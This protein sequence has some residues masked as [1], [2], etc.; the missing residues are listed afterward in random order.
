MTI[1]HSHSQPVCPGCETTVATPM[2]CF[3]CNSIQRLNSKPNYFEV[4]NL[5]YTYDLDLTALEESYQSLAAELHPDFY[6]NAPVSE[7]RQSQESSAL[8]NQAYDT[9]LSPILRA[10]YLLEL[11]AHGK[12]LDERKLPDGFLQEMFFLQETLEDTLD[13][14]NQ[15]KIEEIETSV[16][17][18]LDKSNHGISQSFASYT[19]SI[20]KKAVLENIQILLN[21]NTYL[22][23]LLDRI[24]R[25]KTL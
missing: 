19:G 3:S 9:L 8:L 15:Q 12:K 13:S 24:N 17:E 20:D 2:F 5:P 16:K 1:E 22:Q 23:R 14:G 18:R 4:F 11:L 25:S 6:L 10:R 7:R 21:V